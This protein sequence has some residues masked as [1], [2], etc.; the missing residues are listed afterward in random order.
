MGIMYNPTLNFRKHFFQRGNFFQTGTLFH[1]VNFSRGP[2]GTRL[3]MS[4]GSSA[5]FRRIVPFRDTSTME[6][7][8]PSFRDAKPHEP[9]ELVPLDE[10]SLAGIL[11]LWN[12]R[13]LVSGMRRRSNPCWHLVIARRD[14]V[15][16]IQASGTSLRGA[17][18]SWQS[19]LQKKD[20]F[21]PVG[22][23]MTKNPQRGC[24]K[25]EKHSKIVSESLGKW[26]NAK[27]NGEVIFAAIPSLRAKR[28]SPH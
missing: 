25:P 3:P 17:I 5:S 21:T 11:Q 20:C 15:V 12:Q 1:K 9:W 8:I 22:F 24:G 23:A 13:F 18:A 14:S 7:K 27:H 19:C 16:A 10:L 26:K 4:L 28:A 6:S 2:R